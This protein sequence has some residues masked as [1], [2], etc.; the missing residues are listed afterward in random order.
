MVIV[1]VGDARAGVGGSVNDR[2]ALADVVPLHHV[3][4]A[5]EQRIHADVV[6]PDRARPVRTGG[7]RVAKDVIVIYGA[8][9]L[10]HAAALGGG[11]VVGDNVVKGNHCAPLQ[12]QTT[13][14]EK[15][16]KQLELLATTDALSG[17][18]NRRYVLE[19]ST[20]LFETARR[21][22]QNLS[23]IMLDIDDF[24][25]IN[26]TF[27]HAIGD[28]VIAHCATMLTK[29]V[30]NTDVLARY[31]GEEFLIILPN[32]PN[33]EVME[34]ATRIQQSAQSHVFPHAPS[35]QVACT[36]SIGIA[37]LNPSDDT[38]EHLIQRADQAM[39]EAKS[40]GKNCIKQ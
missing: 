37:H 17:L 27:G 33:N 35:E 7:S 30:R 5:D 34:L 25:R 36:F 31:G 1:I 39:Y 22:N 2:G 3:P 14:L 11:A 20:R 19:V 4:G 24:K 21:Y 23:V 9:S 6:G 29:N 8:N 28:D 40:E 26:D 13:A 12:E 32:T 15:T 10:A 18:Y 38:M 16:Q